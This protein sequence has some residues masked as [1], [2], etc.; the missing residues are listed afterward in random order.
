[1]KNQDFG[2]TYPPDVVLNVDVVYWFH[3]QDNNEK[4]KTTDTERNQLYLLFFPPN[5]RF[6]RTVHEKKSLVRDETELCINLILPAL[7]HNLGLN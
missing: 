3:H 1:M 2:G 7:Q 6:L 5:F 4:K